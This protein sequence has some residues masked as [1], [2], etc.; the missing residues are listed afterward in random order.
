M[1]GVRGEV[2]GVVIFAPGPL[3]LVAERLQP[4]RQL[5][6]TRDQARLGAGP[7]AHVVQRRGPVLAGGRG[8]HEAD[9]D[10][11]APAAGLAQAVGDPA[12]LA[13]DVRLTRRPHQDHAVGHPPGQ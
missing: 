7:G 6:E 8:G 9:L 2:L 10:L 12:H 13:P 3:D 11:V 4:G 5:R 1:A